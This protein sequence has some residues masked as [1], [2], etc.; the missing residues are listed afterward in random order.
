MDAKAICEVLHYP[1][2]TALKTARQR[3]ILP[4]SPITIEHRRG[5]F[6]MTNEIAEV[7]ERIERERTLAAAPEKRATEDSTT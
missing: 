2:M 1:T 6:A 3:G 5:V 7:L 4:F